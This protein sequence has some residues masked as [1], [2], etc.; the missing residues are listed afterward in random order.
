[1]KPELW[2]RLEAVF[3]TGPV[4][5]FLGISGGRDASL[6]QSDMDSHWSALIVWEFGSKDAMTKQGFS[7]PLWDSENSSWLV[8][9]MGWNAENNEQ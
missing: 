8:R 4:R 1:M 5:S 9:L 7:I 3:K 2:A 6:A